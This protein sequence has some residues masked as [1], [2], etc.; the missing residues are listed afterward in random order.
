MSAGSSLPTL[1]V[2]VIVLGAAVGMWR[3]RRR[4]WRDPALWAQPLAAGLLIATLLP[5][6]VPV[7]AHRLLVL[8]P[9]ATDA[10]LRALPWLAPIVSLPGA[11]P[12]LR[13]EPQPDLATALRRHPLASELRVIGNGLPP[14]DI[15]AV[16][17]RAL[18]F[19]AAPEAGIVELDAPRSLPLGTQMVIRG[20]LSAPAIRVA[21]SDPSGTQADAA[22]VDSEGRFALSIA[23]RAVGPMRFELRA[24]DG[25]GQSVDRAGV[26]VLIEPGEPLHAVLRAGT[27]DADGKYWRRWAQDAGIDVDYRAG[28]SAGV[29]ISA[30]DASGGLGAGTLQQADVAIID[31]R[32]WSEFSADQRNAVLAAVDAGLGLL[33]KIT[34]P[35][36]GTTAA[37]WASL[38]FPTAA[39]DGPVT[40]TLDRSL[41]MHERAA[42]T[43]APVAL[44]AD[45]DAA[46][47]RPLLTADDGSLLAA[48][49][50]RGA[51]RIA[52]WRLL[53]SYRLVLA[54]E[55][56]RYGAL[57]G[58]AIGALGRAAPPLPAG[59]DLPAEAWVDERAVLCRLGATASLLA[60]DDQTRMQALSVRSD[61]CAGAW[62]GEPGWYRVDSGGDNALFAVRGA[63]DARGLRAVRD[64]A[65]TARLLREPVAGAAPQWQPLPTSRWPWFIAWLLV[66][67]LL[68][69]RERQAPD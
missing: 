52:V 4:R 31:E 51:G 14:R 5:P 3:A 45:P 55:A 47:L 7:D 41:A 19:D 35:L 69:W 46:P 1:V 32:A 37:D 53:D 15:D 11:P 28:L 48:W 13:A 33:L 66:T 65:A 44:R 12:L 67:G 24:F 22:D 17:G 20:R 38:G 26:A 42:F 18:S 56:A 49:R 21:L 10:Q 40:L 27:P 50:P 62:P 64:R 39:L 68:W 29:S 58:K 59:P 57:W 54:G 8:T 25:D 30:G 60:P 36:P 6:S 63:D 34:G 43:A 2:L 9:G 61:G 16:G 23:A